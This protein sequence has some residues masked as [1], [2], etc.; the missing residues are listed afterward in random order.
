[1]I[2]TID[3]GTS[4]IKGAIFLDSR[5][6]RG[7][8]RFIYKKQDA[9]SWLQALDKLLSSLTWPERADLEAIVIS[10]QGPT[11]VPVLKSEEV[12]KPLFYYQNN[13]MAAEGSDPIESYFLPKVAH[14]L[15]KK[16]DLASEIQYFMS[17][18]DYIAYWLTGEAVTSLPNEAYRNLIWSEQEQERYHFQ[19]KW[20]PPY[21]MHREVGVV[22]QE[23]RSRF[24]LQR[25]VVVYTTL[26]DF[27]SALVGSGTIQEGDVLNRAGMSEGVNF[28]MSHIPSVGDLPKTDTY[29]RITPHLLPNLYN[30]GVV[31]DHVGRFMEE[32]NYNTEEAEVQLHIAKM[33]RIWNEFSGL[34]ISLVRLCGGQTYYADVSRLKRRLSHYPL[35]VLRYTQAELLGNVMYATWLRGYYNSLEESVAHFMQIMH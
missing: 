28:I 9:K 16:P 1:M 17:A 19:K 26:F 13:H 30:V 23:Q 25:K 27:L 24:L 18:P 8:G 34:S 33:T 4:S 20:F 35:Q 14:L 10:G 21:A 7:L 6:L 12:L 15:H 31:F 5:P 11:I 22:R 2:L 29:W 3:L 32:Y